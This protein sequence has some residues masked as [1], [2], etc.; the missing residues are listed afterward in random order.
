MSEGDLVA[1]GPEVATLLGPL[2][3]EG[4]R[5]EVA[6]LVEYRCAR[7]D[8]LA[9]PSPAAPASLL[10]VRHGGGHRA[11][12]A[13][14]SC[15]PSRVLDDVGLQVDAA[16]SREPDDVR[17]QVF[18]VDTGTVQVAVVALEVRLPRT[19]VSAGGDPIDPLV[20]SL[21]GDGWALVT[22][23][24]DEVPW[25]GVVLEVDPA[26]GHGQISDPDGGV[27]L[28]RLPED[29]P[30]WVALA[31]AAGRVLVLIGQMGLHT[32]D[33]RGLD[34]IFEAI[35]AGRVVGAM[36]EVHAVGS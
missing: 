19:L 11:V 20:S 8:R 6:R 22:G 9:T 30:Q 32:V 35:A 33:Q 16:R 36:A 7:C 4:L 14:A 27:L 28:D 15:S 31:G 3:L 2:A 5:A 26:T 25:P 10:L 12:L 29:I 13:H 17:T 23:L 34:P 21:L 24:G 18:A 1:I